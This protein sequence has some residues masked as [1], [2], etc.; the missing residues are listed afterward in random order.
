[1]K[2]AIYEA[3][4]E[5]ILNQMKKLY[6]K[7]KY[8]NFCKDPHQIQP[9]MKELRISDA[10]LKFKIKTGM[11]PTI[12]MNFMS[13]QEFSRGPVQDAWGGGTPKPTS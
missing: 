7:I 5:E 11:T 3:N 10:R 8:E 1:M 12:Q 13:D 2:K 9:Y 6:K 4:R